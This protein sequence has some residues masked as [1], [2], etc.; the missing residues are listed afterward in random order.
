MGLIRH[1]LLIIG[2]SNFHP[3]VPFLVSLWFPEA[4][5]WSWHSSF[6]PSALLTPKC[7]KHTDYSDRDRDS[8]TP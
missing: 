8:I 6:E 7:P 3:T 2:F 5:S 1:I 4:L